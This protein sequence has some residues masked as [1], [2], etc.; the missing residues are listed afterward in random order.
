MSEPVRWLDD[1]TST[2]ALRDAIRTLPAHAPELRAEVVE[3]VATSLRR[4][5]PGSAGGAAIA[6]FVAGIATIALVLTA[7]LR[8]TAEPS[9]D[10][11]VMERAA[12]E[13][14]HELHEIGAPIARAPLAPVDR[15]QSVEALIERARPPERTRPARDRADDAPSAVSA[16]SGPAAPAESEADLLRRA[17]RA[18]A[19]EP[20]AA[21]SLAA[22][23]EAAHPRGALALEREVVAIDALLRLGRTADAEARR[24][25]LDARYPNTLY[26]ERIDHLF[27]DRE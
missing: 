20:A 3:G 22:E 26:R 21:L 1:P 17:R 23:H 6:G 13:A 7:V 18:L 12:I 5:A 27:R 11:T 24:A 10:K 2:P 16:T 15:S 19:S 25:A 9:H 4:R 14:P 8:P